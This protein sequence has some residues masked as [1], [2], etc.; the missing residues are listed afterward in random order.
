MAAVRCVIAA[1]HGALSEI[2]VDGVIGGL[3]APGSAEYSRDRLWVTLRIPRAL[4]PRRR[5]GESA[6]RINSRRAFISRRSQV[7][8]RNYARLERSDC[9]PVGT[10]P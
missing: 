5:P 2:V 1:N 4:F 9:K 7:L 3:V 10:M 8:S 6:L